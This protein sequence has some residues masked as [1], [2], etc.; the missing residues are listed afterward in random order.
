M[1]S[2]I[3]FPNPVMLAVIRSLEHA[4]ELARRNEL[5]GLAISYMNTNRALYE[6][7]EAQDAF[8]AAVVLG[9]ANLM[10]EDL[11]QL[12]RDLRDSEKK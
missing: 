6:C 5:A 1:S 2:V 11:R 10:M 4:L 3:Q 8:S 7:L 9:Q 12:T